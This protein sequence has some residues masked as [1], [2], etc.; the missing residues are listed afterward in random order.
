MKDEGFVPGAWQTTFILHPSCFILTQQTPRV[1][2]G[3]CLA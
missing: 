3:L 1:I 2:D